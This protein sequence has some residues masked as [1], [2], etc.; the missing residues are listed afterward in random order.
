METQCAQGLAT[1]TSDKLVNDSEKNFWMKSSQKK[2]NG[3]KAQA[4]VA[5]DPW[6]RDKPFEQAVDEVTLNDSRVIG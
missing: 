6:M 3:S 1:D 4:E 5:N 2:V